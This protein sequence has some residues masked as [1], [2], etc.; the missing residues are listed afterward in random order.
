MIINLILINNDNSKY[1]LKN[2]N[3]MGFVRRKS[4]FI[5]SCKK[6]KT[7]NFIKVSKQFFEVRNIFKLQLQLTHPQLLC[8]VINTHPLHQIHATPARYKSESQVAV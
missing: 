6:H 8:D 3:T 5:L 4:K 7:V 1:I 2:I